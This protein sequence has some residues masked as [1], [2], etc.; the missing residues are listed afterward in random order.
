[1]NNNICKYSAHITRSQILIISNYFYTN[2][3]QTKILLTYSR[4]SS[5]LRI[6]YTKFIN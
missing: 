6:R 5:W 4:E 3:Y 1:M 2:F